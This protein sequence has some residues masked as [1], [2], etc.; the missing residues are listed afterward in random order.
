MMN[1]RQ[2]IAWLFLFIYLGLTLAILTYVFEL[3]DQYT[4]LA[5][6]HTRLYHAEGQKERGS[7]WEHLADV[8]F[9]IW[10]LILT[11][12]YL[13]IFFVIFLCTRAE[14]GI[15]VGKC[16][17]PVVGWLHVLKEWKPE[18]GLGRKSSLSNGSTTCY[19]PANL[20]YSSTGG[21]AYTGV[22][23]G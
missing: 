4:M 3:S 2:R 16:L 12:P 9:P 22:S 5:L 19:V 11:I 14:P 17:L 21:T 20:L 7:F 10:F 1:F 8:P 15:H 6:E 18:S 23:I 13:Q